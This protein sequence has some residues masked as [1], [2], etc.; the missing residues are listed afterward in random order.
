MNAVDIVILA[1]LAVLLFKGVWLGFIHEA[2]GL[3]GL[4]VGS[5]VAARYHVALAGT[6]P[7]WAG[8]PQ[9]LLSAACFAVL[10][11]AS[12]LGFVLL[13]ILLSR[14]IKLVFLGGFNRVLGGLFGLVQGV[15]LLALVLYGFSQT[16]WFKGSRQQSRLTP[17]FVALG[18]QLMAGGRQLL[19]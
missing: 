13:G 3:A 12:V 17:P 4:G 1:V 19:R 8:L 7:A 16:D 14:F 15:V 10:F 11:L 5:V 9:W 6:L 2:C 18:E